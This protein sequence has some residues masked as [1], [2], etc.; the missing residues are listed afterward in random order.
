MLGS[1]T[2]TRSHRARFHSRQANCKLLDCRTRAW[3]ITR[4]LYCHGGAHVAPE[5]D[6]DTKKFFSCAFSRSHSWSK[7]NEAGRPRRET[8]ALSAA[9]SSKPNHRLPQLRQNSSK[10]TSAEDLFR[11]LVDPS[12]LSRDEKRDG[13]ETQPNAVGNAASNLNRP[14]AD[15]ILPDLTWRDPLKADEELAPRRT[16]KAGVSRQRVAAI[17]IQPTIDHDPIRKDAPAAKSPRRKSRPDGGGKFPGPIPAMDSADHVGD[18]G[19]QGDPIK[20]FRQ[21][22]IKRVRKHVADRASPPSFRRGERWKRRL[23]KV[24]W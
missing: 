20:P 11:D 16:K 7:S 2:A 10:R 23:P 22:S 19:A 5:A 24:L 21:R 17:L 9:F 8:A 13:T 12:Y 1:R 6:L 4:S 14:T 18:H 3:P 15:R